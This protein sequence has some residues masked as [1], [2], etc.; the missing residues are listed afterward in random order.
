MHTGIYRKFVIDESPEQVLKAL[1][2]D[3]EIVVKAKRNVPNTDVPVH[4]KILTTS[5]AFEILGYDR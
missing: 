3:G 1:N 2:L 5:E 4:V